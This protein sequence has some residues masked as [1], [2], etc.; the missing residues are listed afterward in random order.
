MRTK[1]C[2]HSRLRRR[3]TDGSVLD[4]KESD[5]WYV[6]RVR[7]CQTN[8]YNQCKLR[9]R[10]RKKKI[11]ISLLCVCGENPTFLI[12]S[13]CEKITRT[14][15]RSYYIAEV[16]LAGPIQRDRI[17]VTSQNKNMNCIRQSSFKVQQK[18][19]SADLDDTAVAA[20]N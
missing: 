13:S 18:V 14:L 16:N 12:S 20:L 7:K 5:F 2:A 8:F 15:P 17:K 4:K 19:Q 6:S 9:G 3:Q 11:C 10:L 1:N